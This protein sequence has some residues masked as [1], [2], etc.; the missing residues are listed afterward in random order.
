M[1]CHT[2]RECGGDDDD[3]DYDIDIDYLDDDEVE[4]CELTVEEKFQ[5]EHAF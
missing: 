5:A 4:E 2:L 1:G 3:E